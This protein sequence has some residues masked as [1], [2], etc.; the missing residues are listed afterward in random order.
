MRA[1]RR[2]LLVGV[3]ATSA[4]V[5][6]APGV[7]IANEV[8]AQ[9]SLV[10]RGPGI[11]LRYPSSLYLS[12]RPLDSM[13]N[14][15]ER[16]VLSTYRVPGDRP[17]AEGSYTP[18]PTGVIAELLEEVPPVDPAFQAPPRPRRFVLPKLRDNLEG[19]GDHWAELPFRA[20]GRDF[21]IFLGVGDRASSAKVALVLRTLDALAISAPP[22]SVSGA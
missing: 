15:V 4:A 22:L 21:Y 17:N 10:F 16:F 5:L 7:G 11:V 14:P 3:V 1:V 13:T 20:H 12:S 6:V 19:F 18:P 8:D 2:A 9:T